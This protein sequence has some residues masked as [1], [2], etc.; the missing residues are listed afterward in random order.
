ME[1]AEQNITRLKQLKTHRALWEPH[2]QEVVD[3]IMPDRP[4]VTRTTQPGQKKTNKIYDDTAG[5]AL[6]LFSS[7]LAGMLTNEAMPWFALRAVDKQLN[8]ADDVKAW[9]EDTESVLYE[10][11]TIS[12]LY[13]ELFSAYQD[14]GGVGTTSL[15]IEPGERQ[16]LAFKTRFI[17]S[18][19]I[20]E[21]KDGNVDTHYRMENMTARQIDQQWPNGGSEEVTQALANNEPDKEFEVLHAVYPRSDRDASKVDAENMLWE[22]IY[23]ETDKKHILETGGYHEFPF[24]VPRFK[25]LGSEWYGRSCGMRAL[26]DTKMLNE[27]CRT[28]LRAAQKA[29]DPPLQGPDEGYI[30]PLRTGPGGVN[31]RS[32][33]LKG[34]E[35]K[36]MDFHADVGLGLEMEEQRRAAIRAKFYWDLWL[37]SDSPQKTAYEVARRYDQATKLLGPQLMRVQIE[38]L[39]TII[40]RSF[41]ILS[42]SGDIL[43]PPDSLRRAGVK[44]EYISPIAKMQRLYQARALQSAFAFVAPLSERSPDIYDRID[45]DEVVDLAI[46]LFGVPQKVLRTKDRVKAIRKGRQ[47]AEYRETQ[48]RAI[49]ESVDIA[50]KASKADPGAGL[51]SLLQPQGDA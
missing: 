7:G 15:S 38:L 1:K 33:H 14:L 29:V 16:P 24:A 9:L 41:G 3:Y 25:K 35:F 5:E 11:F 27:M 10:A 45:P 42:R 47:E 36:A 34:D 31:Y 21:D 17:N 20:A 13:Q 43:P 30:M 32:P 50:E 28:T 37:L 26:A 4:G 48:R 19:Y 39:R 51:L 2:W 40:L 12:R 22:S 23:L 8:D 44:V 18:I 49:G 46:D 6:D